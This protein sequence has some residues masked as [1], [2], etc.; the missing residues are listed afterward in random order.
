MPGATANYA[1]PYQ[2]AGDSPNGAQGQ[3]NLAQAV[4]TVLTRMDTVAATT[5]FTAGGSWVKPTGC[6]YVRVRLVGGGGGGGVGFSTAAGQGTAAGGGGGGGYAEEIIPASS[7]TSSTTVTVGAGGLG[8]NPPT[9]GGTSSFGAFLS[10]TGGAPG[11]SSSPATNTTA[12]G[13]Q[14]GVGTG[15]TI[16]IDGED[17][18]VGRVGNG[19]PQSARGGSS[20]LGAGGR[21]GTGVNVAVGAIGQAYGGGGSGGAC[22]PVNG[23]ALGGNGTQGVVIVE[24][25][26]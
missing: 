8:A 6:R 23:P 3:Q 19:E 10:A 15:G 24:A 20:Q 16:N 17:G 7:L 14:G 4:D 1:L 2:Q 11:T 18:S 5:V 9:A 25:Y 12:D 13:G 22:R 26:F 21:E